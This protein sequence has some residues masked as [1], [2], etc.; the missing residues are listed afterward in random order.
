ME[1]EEALRQLHATTAF[2]FIGGK[3]LLRD[4]A[5]LKAVADLRREAAHTEPIAEPLSDLGRYSLYQGAAR[6]A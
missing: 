4:A 1:R 5:V 2:K 3:V 6:S